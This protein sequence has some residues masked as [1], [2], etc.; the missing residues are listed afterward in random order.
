MAFQMKGQGATEYLVLLAVVLIIALVSISLLG[1]FPGLASDAKITQSSTY[2]RGE[3]API[4]IQDHAFSSTE[5]IGPGELVLLNNDASG[6]VT[7]TDIIL[8]DSSTGAPIFSSNSSDYTMSPSPV[9]LPSGAQKTVN[10][11]SNLPLGAHTSNGALYQFK[12]T[13]LYTRSSG[14]SQA[15]YGATPLTG[16]YSD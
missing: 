15:E 4:S 10:L 12:V 1:F 2:W 6:T 7:I 5:P 14:L 8:T 3:A 16:K 9:V 11:S 13:I